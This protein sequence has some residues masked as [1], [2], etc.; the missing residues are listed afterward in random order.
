MSRLGE[1]L[2]DPTLDPP[3]DGARRV[4]L[5]PARD[6]AERRA[7]PRAAWPATTCSRSSTSSSSPTRPATPTSCC[8]R[9]R[10]SRATDVVP[11][12]GHL[13]MGWNE[14]AIA[15]A[16]RVVQQH[17]AVPPARRR[18]GL[19]RAGAVRRRR[20]DPRSRRSAQK[21]DLDE[22]APRRLGQGA[23]PRGRPAVG[24][25]RVPDG[26]GQGRARQRAA[27]RDGPAGAA[28]VRR[29]RARARTAIPTLSPRFPLQLLTPK[30][31]TRFLNSSYSPAA[32]ARPGRGRRRSSSSTPPTPPPAASPTATWPRCSTTGPASTCRCA[33]A[34]GVRPGVVAIPFG[35]WSAQHP[36]GRVANALTNDT[37]TDWGGGVA[38]QR[39]AGRRSRKA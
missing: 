1:V 3:V 7:D 21:V 22:L 19:H 10:R 12:W 6:R 5:Q 23:V 37:L 4:E 30:H 8:R 29:R 9:R 11:A 13:W 14:A 33:S 35:W 18:D 25:R 31:H 32:Q 20:D 15:P 28:D 39:H 17:R 2:T 38:Y 16:R 26:V 27:R 34:T 24:R 36:D